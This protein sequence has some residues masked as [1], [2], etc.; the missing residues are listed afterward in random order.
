[1]MKSL[2]LI[3][4]IIIIIQAIVINELIKKYRST[5]KYSKFMEEVITFHKRKSELN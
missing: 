1:M 4:I 2:V 5:I 3:L